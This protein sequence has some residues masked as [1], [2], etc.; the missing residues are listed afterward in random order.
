MSLEGVVQWLWVVLTV[1][2]ILGAIY[3]ALRGEL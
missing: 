2:V 3:L 1:A